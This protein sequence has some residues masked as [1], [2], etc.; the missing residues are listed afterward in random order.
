MLKSDMCAF[1]LSHVGLF[2]APRIHQD[3]LSTNFPGKNTGVGC[4]FILQ[5]IF[6]TEGLNSCLLASPALEVNSLSLV[7]PGKVAEPEMESRYLTPKPELLL[8]SC[9]L[10]CLITSEF[11]QLL[12]NVI[13]FSGL[14]KGNKHQFPCFFV[15]LSLD[16]LPRYNVLFFIC[17]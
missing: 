11:F 9:I 1:M 7:S 14:L 10:F 8:Q 5:G 2:E 6:L 3:P 12:E 13:F 16:Y 17:P 15:V 4:H